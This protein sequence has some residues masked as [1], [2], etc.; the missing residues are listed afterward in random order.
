MKKI[1]F[2]SLVLFIGLI[3]CNDSSKKESEQIISAYE[4]KNVPDKREVVFDVQ[5]VLEQDNLVIAG[6]TS[7]EK[8]KTGLLNELSSLKF[9]D[10]ITVLPDSTVGNTHF[11]L[12]NVP[13]ANLRSTP[14]NSAE[15]V[16]QAILG[17]PVKLL[18]KTGGWYRVQTPDRY[19]SWIDN[20]AITPLTDSDFVN[21]RNSDRLICKVL[22]GQVFETENLQNPVSD[23]TL[24][25]ILQRIGQNSNHLTK[26]IFPDGR[27]G[28]VPSAEWGDF[29][30]FK[31]TVKP[32]PETVISLAKKLTG[33][34][35]LWGGTSSNIMDCSGFVKIVYFMN[36]LI[37]ARDASLQALHGETIDTTEN[38]TKMHPGDLFFFGR[39]SSD[40]A[41]AKVTHVAISLGGTN[42]IHASGMVKQN[43]FDP[44]SEVYSEYRKNSLIV[45]K[46]VINSRDE[47]IQEIKEHPW[48]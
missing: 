31:N 23:V 10:K 41:K 22:N 27:T 1:V 21:W 43:S 26:I 35:Y 16:S 39:K 19:I 37:L 17:T 12:V 20:A 15:L 34:A 30:A 28:F 46:R 48:Y 47:G 25:C 9:K 2:I 8:L 4:N 13:V 11:A 29:N 24:G 6:E 38:F 14:D 32:K 40:S 33:R 44:T 7:D 18:Q 36:G 5:A 45:A 42:Y 3:S